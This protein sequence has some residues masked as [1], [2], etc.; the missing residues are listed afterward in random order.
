MA[1]LSMANSGLACSPQRQLASVITVVVAFL[2]GRVECGGYYPRDVEL[3]GPFAVDSPKS[4]T[5]QTVYYYPSYVRGS[6]PVEEYNRRR[7]HVDTSS[8]M[9]EMKRPDEEKNKTE[10]EENLEPSKRVRNVTEDGG[11]V[12]NSLENDKTKRKLSRKNKSSWKSKVKSQRNGFPKVKNPIKRIGSDEATEFEDPIETRDRDRKGDPRRYEESDPHVFS[13][14]R[15]EPIDG[16]AIN[17]RQTHPPPEDSKYFQYFNFFGDG[18]Y[19][20][21]T[22]RGN[23]R[24]YI[25][26]HERG[27]KGVGVF[28]KR[29]KWADKDG[30]F[31]E[32]YWDLNHV[33]DE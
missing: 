25:E 27:S 14:E 1:L 32:H 6:D 30:G 9:K 13:Y 12:R 21:G 31:G 20:A 24:H 11:K 4:S 15:S 18:S 22:K 28:Q 7:L 3:I 19:N 10:S 16:D 2:L 23:N 26:Q 33:S 17:R 8:Y 5:D 29:V